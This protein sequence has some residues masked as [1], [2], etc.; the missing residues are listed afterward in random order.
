[1]ILFKDPPF[2]RHYL[3][4][5]RERLRAD[6]QRESQKTSLARHREQRPN[7]ELTTTEEIRE[8]LSDIDRSRA[9]FLDFR[10]I[11]SF[12]TRPLPLVCRVYR[13]TNI[14]AGTRANVNG[15][16]RDTNIVNIAGDLR[17]YAHAKYNYDYSTNYRGSNEVKN[18]L[19][20]SYRVKLIL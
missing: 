20:R 8:S 1:M 14:F 15:L 5:P 4:H 10:L 19:A 9:V 2:E 13:R 17:T 7:R 11:P 6:S 3:E 12:V 18:L 16:S